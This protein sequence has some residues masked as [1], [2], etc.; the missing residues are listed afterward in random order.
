MIIDS[1]AISVLST[2]AIIFMRVCEEVTTE[3]GNGP[4]GPVCKTMIEMVLILEHYEA[5]LDYMHSLE[6]ST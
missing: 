2:C 1:W 3:S 6:W 4:Y 5:L